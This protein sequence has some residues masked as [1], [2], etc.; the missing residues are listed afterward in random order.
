MWRLSPVPGL[1]SSIG[2]ELSDKTKRTGLLYT[3]KEYFIGF[4]IIN[5]NDNG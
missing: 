4:S 5:G 2:R 1:A 3:S